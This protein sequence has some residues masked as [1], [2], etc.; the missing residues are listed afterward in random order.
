MVINLSNPIVANI[1]RYFTDM[2]ERYT[3]KNFVVVMTLSFIAMAAIYGF[4]TDWAK[5]DE[6]QKSTVEHIMHVSQTKQ[7]SHEDA[8]NEIAKD[9]DVILDFNTA[10]ADM[11]PSTL[12]LCI[13]FLLTVPAIIKR[14]ND[15]IFNRS[16]SYPVAIYYVIY[17]LQVIINKPIALFGFTNAL[18][19]YTFF[20]VSIIALL[21]THEEEEEEA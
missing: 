16:S 9:Q 20:F 19:L 8:L 1:Y 7:I 18:A 2:N 11:I 4:G 21:P 5:Y 10:V 6:L 14:T 15:C 13:I 3:R 12:W 17:A